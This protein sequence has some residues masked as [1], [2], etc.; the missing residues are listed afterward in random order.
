M[1]VYALLGTSTRIVLDD[2]VLGIDCNPL[3]ER[4]D[5]ARNDLS[6]G[7]GLWLRAVTRGST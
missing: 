7:K 1:S 4:S 3:K 6:V 5:S 2:S